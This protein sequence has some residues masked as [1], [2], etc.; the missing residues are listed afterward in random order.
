MNSIEIDLDAEQVPASDEYI[1]VAPEQGQQI[2]DYFNG[3]LDR[4]NADA[5]EEHAVLCHRCRERLETLD[6]VFRTL[7][8]MRDEYSS[9]EQQE[10]AETAGS[11]SFMVRSVNSTN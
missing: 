2:Y 1:C 10:V 4:K 3:L 7:R 8:E 5:F 11:R 9:N 6:W